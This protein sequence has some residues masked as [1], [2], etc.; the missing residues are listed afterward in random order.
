MEEALIKAMNSASMQAIQDT[1]ELQTSPERHFNPTF[2]LSSL[3]F[4]GKKK[5]GR[6]MEGLS[7]R[8]EEGELRSS[9]NGSS[10][11]VAIP[12]ADCFSDDGWTSR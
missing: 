8:A 2:F 6:S 5:N 3:I 1:R 9:A 10:H 7:K 11:R 12:L 4:S